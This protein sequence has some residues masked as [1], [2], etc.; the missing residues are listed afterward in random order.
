LM[1]VSRKLDRPATI[2]RVTLVVTFLAIRLRQFQS[3]RTI[4]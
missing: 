1:R 4:H 3:E 2:I